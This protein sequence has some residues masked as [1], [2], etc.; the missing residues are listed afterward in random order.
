MKK[1]LIAILVVII[2]AGLGVGGYFTYVKVVQPKL[3]E[4]E[5]QDMQQV[6]ALGSILNQDINETETMADQTQDGSYEESLDQESGISSEDGG[7]LI[8]GDSTTDNN[9]STSNQDKYK[10]LEELNI[11]LTQDSTKEDI[12]YYLE[13]L[14]K[15]DFVSV[16]M[17]IATMPTQS[18]KLKAI[19]TDHE[20]WNYLCLTKD[21]VDKYDI[22]NDSAVTEMIRS[23]Y[24]EDD[25]KADK[26]TE[27]IKGAL[28]KLTSSEVKQKFEFTGS[29]TGRFIIFGGKEYFSVSLYYVVED[30]IETIFNSE[31]YPAYMI[32]SVNS[33]GDLTN[34]MSELD[35]IILRF[36]EIL[37]DCASDSKYK[38]YSL[39]NEVLNEM[40][41][42]YKDAQESE[43][44]GSIGETLEESG[45]L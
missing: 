19:C 28:K 20:K 16:G 15:D 6:D 5:Q 27:V 9:E 18:E 12:R 10:T 11:P 7:D 34:Y 32:A 38:V 22:N 25:T 41:E 33:N 21:L 35:D 1:V 43:A 29:Q 44:S 17:G 37:D 3:E 45:Q 40:N 24:D 23:L 4:K 14:S 36:N 30:N 31:G 39:I 42:E 2:L 13:S 26:K 8:S